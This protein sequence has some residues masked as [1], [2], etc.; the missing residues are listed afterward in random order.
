VSRS[1]DESEPKLES[2]GPSAHQFDEEDLR[3]SARLLL[4]I[5]RQPGPD[6]VATEAPPSLTQA[7]M[8]AALGTSQA[9]VSNA[10]NRLVQGGALKVESRAVWR[11]L[12]RSKVY[13]LTK[14]G[15]EL[16]HH[17]QDGMTR[18]RTRR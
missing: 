14:D 16:V 9:S 6:R 18:R 1:D 13:F 15:E 11:K 4:H 5:A 7:G 17:I 8:A 3:I 12:R 2:P 10:L